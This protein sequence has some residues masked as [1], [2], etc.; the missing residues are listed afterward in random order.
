MCY[1]AVNIFTLEPDVAGLN[2]SI[3]IQNIF[4]KNYNQLNKK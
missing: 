1:K 2:P 3:E 4:W